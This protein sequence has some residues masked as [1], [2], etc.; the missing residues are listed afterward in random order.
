MVEEQRFVTASLGEWSIAL[1][2]NA[3][4]EVLELASLTRVPLTPPWM[5]GL[6]NLRGQVLPVVDLAA[7]LDVAHEAPT[8]LLVADLEGR[9]LGLGLGDVGD[10]VR[11]DEVILEIPRSLAPELRRLVH[12]LIAVSDRVFPVLDAGVLVEQIA[13]AR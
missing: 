5:L 3:V 2:A 12:V 4:A 7:V 10:V 1:A 13:A 8:R 6:C 9:C 11:A